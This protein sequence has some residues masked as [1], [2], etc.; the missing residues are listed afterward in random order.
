M[1]IQFKKQVGKKHSIRYIREGI[2]DHWIEADDFL[3]LHDLCHYAI[4]SSLG[5]KN[6]FWGMIS[7]GIDPEIFLDKQKRDQLFISDEAWYAEHIAHLFLIEFT[8]GEFEDINS[9]FRDTLGQ[10][11]PDIP[12]IQYS[13]EEIR[14]IRLLIRRRVEEWREI[15]AGE[16]MVLHF[17]I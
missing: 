6:A 3:V 5:Y 15:P 9:V 11:H 10:T 1:E 14:R 2:A 7:Q 12:L 17:L 13:A 16:S 4:E 8:Q